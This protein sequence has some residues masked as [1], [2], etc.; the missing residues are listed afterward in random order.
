M[1]SKD[2]DQTV[3]Q[4]L[5]QIFVLC[6]QVLR[7]LSSFMIGHLNGA[8]EGTAH[9]Y[10]NI[11]C[12][13]GEE[14]IKQQVG[15]AAREG[16][17]ANL[18]GNPILAGAAPLLSNALAGLCG[19]LAAAAVSE[20]DLTREIT[21]SL[22]ASL[23]TSD[24]GF[25]RTRAHVCFLKGEVSV[26]QLTVLVST[27]DISSLFTLTV[28]PSLAAWYRWTL[29]ALQRLRLH[30][31][32]RIIDNAFRSLVASHLARFFGSSAEGMGEQLAASSGGLLK[33]HVLPLAIE[34][35]AEHL[36]SAL[37]SMNIV[38]SSAQKREEEERWRSAIERW[39]AVGERTRHL[40]EGRHQTVIST[41]P[42]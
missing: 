2:P 25:A 19:N 18:A 22:A 10:L 35:E 32:A 39:K 12:C 23:N 8:P 1:R 26:I 17:S 42:S 41:E 38:G 27:D 21:T 6:F 31:T 30:S 5:V 36:F 20:E 9:T 15:T 40:W 11:R 14:A 3:S 7:G 24:V 28:G 33:V 29:G 13:N 16:V 34:N 37:R 4:T